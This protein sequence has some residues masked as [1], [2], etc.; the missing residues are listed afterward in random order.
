[1]NCRACAPIV[2]IY[3]WYVPTVQIRV[4]ATA[5]EARLAELRYEYGQCATDAL[6]QA[7]LASIAQVEANYY[8]TYPARPLAWID[9]TPPA[10]IL[11]KITRKPAKQPA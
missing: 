7:K 5:Y 8:R 6:R 1:M 11:R 3:R 4:K 2:G 9:Y 10:P